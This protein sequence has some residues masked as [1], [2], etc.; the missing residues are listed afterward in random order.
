LQQPTL[1]LNAL[2]LSFEGTIINIEFMQEADPLGLPVQFTTSFISN[3]TDAL[4]AEF[5]TGDK[6]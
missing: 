5:V 2:T 6:N 4:V 3:A 1:L